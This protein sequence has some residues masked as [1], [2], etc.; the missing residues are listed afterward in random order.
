M[1]THPERHARL[2]ERIAVPYA[3][4]FAG[5]TRSYAE[6]FRIGRAAL[7]R[8]V[9]HQALDIGCGTGAFTQALRSEGWTVQ[10]IDVAQGMVAQARK[11]GVQC[12]VGDI[13]GGLHFADHSFD[14]VS[15][16]YVAHGLLKPQRLALFTEARRLSRDTV[17][18]HDYTADLRPLTS[19]IEW[20]EGGDY[21][22]FILT[23]SDELRAVFGNLQV[24]RVGKQAAWYVCRCAHSAQ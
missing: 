4:F 3:W 21:F 11:R 2:F 10:G 12:A 1:M 15:A 7:P 6:C 23:V 17:L 22:N 13:L 19:L 20:L 5:Q 24:I 16:A 8:P 14:L 18:F 9:G